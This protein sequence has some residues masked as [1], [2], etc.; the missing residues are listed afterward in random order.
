MKW[1]RPV[2][3]GVKFFKSD[4]GCGAQIIQSS[5]TFC[6]A[7]S[8]FLARIDFFL[9]LL[10]FFCCFFIPF[11]SFGCDFLMNLTKYSAISRY[12]P[13]LRVPKFLELGQ[14]VRKQ[15]SADLDPLVTKTTKRP[16][17]T[18]V[19]WCWTNENSLKNKNGF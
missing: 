3:N 9:C 11:H 13:L 7:A 8:A 15:A 16:G 5:S 4:D 2:D 18:C 17:F 14:P 1:Q 19:P 10:T 12:Y 6:L